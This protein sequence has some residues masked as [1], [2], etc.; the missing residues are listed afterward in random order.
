MSMDLYRD[1]I[2]DLYHNPHNKGSLLGHTHTARE[3]NSSCGDEVIVE[4][5]IRE[6]IIVD[7]KFTGVGCAISLAGASLATDAVKG[8][9]VQEI[10][11]YTKRDIDEWFGFDIVYTR[12]NCASLTLRAIQKATRTL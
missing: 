10:T 6:G 2:L 11:G 1:I 9:T 5:L 8:R 3:V 4:L 7:A 12:E